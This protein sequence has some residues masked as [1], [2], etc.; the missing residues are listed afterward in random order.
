MFQFASSHFIKL[1]IHL[2]MHGFLFQCGFPHSEI[3]GSMDICSSPQ[4]IA[5]CHVLH[6]R[7]VPRNSPCALSNLTYYG[8]FLV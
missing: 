2:M 3:C 8:S 6:R 5:A 1:W 7:L 4:L